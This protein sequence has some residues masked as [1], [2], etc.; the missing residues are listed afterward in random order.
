MHSSRRFTNWRLTIALLLLILLVVLLL[1][2]S[3]GPAKIRV[4]TI[5]QILLSRLPLSPVTQGQSAPESAEVIILLLR[6]P[7]AIQAALIGASL[8]VSGVVIQSLFKNPMADPYVVGIS[9]GAALGASTAILLGLGGLL[10]I[11][12]LAFTGAT[13]AAFIVYSIARTESGVVVETLLLSGIAVAY[14]FSAITSFL[15]YTA[16]EALHQIIFWLMGGLWASSWP[17]ITVITPVFILSYV[18]LQLFARD[19]NALLLGEEPAQHLGIDVPIL[20]KIILISA[21]LLAGV[22]VAFAGTIG[23][24]G[25][26]IPHVTRLLVGP[27]HR[28]LLPAS[29][30][31]GAIFLLSSDI[32]ARTLLAPAE[33]PVGVITAFFGAPF[34]I[35]L[36]RT[37]RRGI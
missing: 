4:Q 36:L 25:L 3:I 14:F 31:I 8:A 37:R 21:S 23:F 13:A 27:D 33:I 30:L 9:S 29:A 12:V 24:V 18:V 26:I 6:L 32:L 28:V 11:P 5:F 15:L 2:V 1:S 35:Y 20:K 34:F 17:K 16:G 10:S 19:L 7:R 22:S